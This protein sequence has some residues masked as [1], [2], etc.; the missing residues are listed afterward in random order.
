M[1]IRLALP[2]VLVGATAPLAAQRPTV[3]LAGT[4]LMNAFYNDDAVNNTDVP[5]VATP[6]DPAGPPPAALGATVR[7]TR[8]ALFAVMPNVLA[9]EASAEL[10]VDFF[11][12]QLSGGR[13]HPLLRIRRARVDLR[14]PNGWVMA[15]QE[16]PPIAE[17]NP[18]SLAAVGIPGFTQAGNLWIWLPQVRVG[19]AAGRRVQLGGEIAAVAPRSGEHFGNVAT[20]SDR[21]ERTERPHGEARLLARWG[22]VDTPSEISVGAHYGWLA[23]DADSLVVSRAAAASVRVFATR[24][25]ELRAEAFLG[26]ALTGLGG[27]G[28]G[29]NLAPDGAAVKTK[30]GWAQL[31]L[32]PAFQWEV[33]GGY[34]LE[35][36]DDADLSGV[37]GRGKNV[38][39]E[40][41]TIWRPPPLLVAV[42]Y[43]R[44]ETTYLNPSL[45][46]LTANHLNV[47]VG[48]E[49]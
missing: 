16:A 20:Q 15:G 23:N 42:E 45:G 44:I 27:G 10:D 39:W 13:V 37:A 40:V 21:A 6:P 46:L 26:A 4:I 1:R 48:F 12:G 14:W 30:G 9:G 41:H 19:G 28:I 49:F 35:D 5:L 7:Q 34:G 29:Q 38:Q 17:L 31:N 25:A 11:G 2:F 24:Y 43:R 3:E 32:R 36:P 33:G 8:L 47:A 22:D 18:S